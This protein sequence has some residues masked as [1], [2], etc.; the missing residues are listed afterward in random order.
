L[1]LVAMLIVAG[2]FVLSNTA[3]AG[4]LLSVLRH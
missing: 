2:A 1:S 4:R 3:I